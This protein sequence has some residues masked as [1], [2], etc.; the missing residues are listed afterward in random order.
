MSALVRSITVAVSV[1]VL[2]LSS[3][4]TPV[5]AEEQTPEALRT[6]TIREHLNN[7]LDLSTPFTDEN[8]RPTTLGRYFGDKK[9]VLLS[10]NYYEC[11]ML[12]TIQLNNLILGLKALGW[13]PGDRY[14]IVTIS[15]DPD[16]GPELAAAKRKSYL[17]QLGMGPDVDWNFLVGAKTS[18]DAVAGAVG[19]EYQYDEKS[20]QYAHPAALFF[21]SPDGKVSRYLYGIEYPARDLRFAIVESS[22]GHIGSPIDKLILSC[23]HY[24]STLG[25]YGPFAFGMMRIGGALGVV[26]LGGFLALMW[27]REWQRRHLEGTA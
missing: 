20:G 23:F 13:A 7:T 14:R 15:M 18:I 10:I 11:P 17:E 26:I 16:E 8:G 27:R 3:F 21:L 4:V 24:D 6:V 1:F 19:F 12:C 9:P 25:S 2:T 5:T 22:E